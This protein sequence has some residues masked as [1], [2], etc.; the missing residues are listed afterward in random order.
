MQIFANNIL[1]VCS[2]LFKYCTVKERKSSNLQQ[3]AN[4]LGHRVD[5]VKSPGKMTAVTIDICT[6]QYKYLEKV[7]EVSYQLS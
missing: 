4:Q 2:I 5:M 1:F 3:P 6:S 7:E